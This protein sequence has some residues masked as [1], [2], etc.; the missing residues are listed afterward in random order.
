MLREKTVG[1]IVNK[2]SSDLEVQAK[3]FGKFAT[4]VVSSRYFSPLFY[5]RFSLFLFALCQLLSLVFDAI[6]LLS[7]FS[8]YYRFMTLTTS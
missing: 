1:E 6:S 4:Q 3:G 2:W 7:T 5:T 8:T